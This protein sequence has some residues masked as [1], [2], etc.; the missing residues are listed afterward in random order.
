MSKT[1]EPSVGAIPCEF[2][3]TFVSFKDRVTGLF[4]LTEWESHRT[5]WSVLIT[6]HKCSYFLTRSSSSTGH[7]KSLTK[8][9]PSLFSKTSESTAV[10][11]V[12]PPQKRRRAKRSEQERIDYLRGDSCVADFEAYRVLCASCGKWIRLRPNSTY[13]VCLSFLDLSLV[14]SNV[15]ALV[16]SLGRASQRLPC[17]EGN[18]VSL[19]INFSALAYLKYQFRPSRNGVS[20]TRSSLHRR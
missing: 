14:I 8:P 7:S 19:C 1:N 6:I 4:T 2:C 3:K 16:Y 15:Y 18:L 13:C 17:Q 9:S 20:K 10:S 5:Q 12:S 11:F